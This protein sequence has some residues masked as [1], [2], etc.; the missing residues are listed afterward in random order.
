MEFT[1]V[2]ILYSKRRKQFHISSETE[3]QEKQEHKSVGGK[4]N[5]IRNERFPVEAAL[6]TLQL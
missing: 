3:R 4:A 5:P 6:Q 1:T 2:L